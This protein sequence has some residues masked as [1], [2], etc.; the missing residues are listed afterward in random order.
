MGLVG[1]YRRF[2]NDFSVIASL[3]T[4]LLKKYVKFEWNDKCQ[5]SFDQLKQLLIEAPVLT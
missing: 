3:L 5:A 4:K 1:Y 2:V